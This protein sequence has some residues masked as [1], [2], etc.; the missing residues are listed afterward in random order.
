MQ[1]P[2]ESRQRLSK[3]DAK[4]LLSDC[5][6]DQILARLGGVLKG[7]PASGWLTINQAAELSG[8]SVRSLQR[9]LA[10]MG[11]S[12]TQISN[13]CR[14]EIAKELLT[15]TDQSLSEIA[16]HL[17]YSESQN[18]IRAFKRGTGQTPEEFRQRNRQ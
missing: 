8:V 6:D 10:A 16:T 17:G 7:Y 5:Q 4:Q 1:S 11:V 18:F 13:E 12:F 3:S 14:L 2:N 15:D 9:R